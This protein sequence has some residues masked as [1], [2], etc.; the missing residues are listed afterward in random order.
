MAKLN[1]NSLPELTKSMFLGQQK[2]SASN[3]D[4]TLKKHSR[5]AEKLLIR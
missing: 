5:D 4:D 2:W 3:W 1:P